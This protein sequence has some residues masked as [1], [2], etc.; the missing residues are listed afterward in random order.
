MKTT[1]II[2]WISTILI[3]LMMTMSAIMQLTQQP[4]LLESMK[5]LGYPSYIM[6]I[7]G[8]AKALGAIALIFPGYPKI[9]EWAYAG[10]T[11]L[12]IGATASHFA[13]GDYEVIT[14]VLLAVLATSYATSRKIA[15]VKK[16][17]FA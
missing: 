6:F 7:L 10:F 8:A 15:K 2:Y 1:K 16:V 13:I 11:F 9:R 14:L 4:Q 3:A 17:S 12:L 5:V